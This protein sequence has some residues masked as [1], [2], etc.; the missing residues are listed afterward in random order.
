[1]K[2]VVQIPK[3]KFETYIEVLSFC[4]LF[5]IFVYVFYMWSEL[6]E[7]I[8]SH[9]DGMGRPDG[10]SGK[11]SILILPIIGLFLFFL[12]TMLGKASQMFNYSTNVPEEK[13]PK[14]YVEGRRLMIALNIEITFFFVIGTWKE[15]QTAIGK[16]DGLGVWFLTSF[17]VILFGTLIVYI[18][19]FRCV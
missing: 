13:A 4:L 15:V 6:P 8:P 14:L 9:F 12:L 3:T 2:E 5:S 10:W 7:R 11:E 19:R 16:A 17:L 18:I 1:M